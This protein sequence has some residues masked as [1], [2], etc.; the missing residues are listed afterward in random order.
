MVHN[1]WR[2]QSRFTQKYAFRAGAETVLR[3]RLYDVILVHRKVCFSFGVCGYARH[4][5]G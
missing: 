2:R 3:Q 5:E 1:R 4:N